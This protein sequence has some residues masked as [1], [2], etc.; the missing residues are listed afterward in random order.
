MMQLSY[1]VLKATG[2]P[3]KYKVHD[4]PT[5]ILIAQQGTVR[6]V[7]IGLSR[8]LR[9]DL[10]KVIKDLL[11]EGAKPKSAAARRRLMFKIQRG[12]AARRP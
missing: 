4:I 8:A 1:W 11:A 10:A 5:L 9:A 12:S 7:H 3:E 2:V 6:D